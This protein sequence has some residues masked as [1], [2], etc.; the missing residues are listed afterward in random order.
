[1]PCSLSLWYREAASEAGVT[2]WK[3]IKLPPTFALLKHLHLI[4]SILPAQ[5]LSCKPHKGKGL[6]FL[7]STLIFQIAIQLLSKLAQVPSYIVTWHCLHSL[8]AVMNVFPL[9]PPHL[10][11]PAPEPTPVTT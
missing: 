11:A 4:P 10:S 5:P 9:S 6:N 7:D 2:L 3:V 8:L 1:M